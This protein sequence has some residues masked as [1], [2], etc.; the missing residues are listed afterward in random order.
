MTSAIQQDVRDAVEP[1]V[2]ERIWL[3]LGCGWETIAQFCPEKRLLS[4]LCWTPFFAMTR[5]NP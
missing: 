5:K 3:R 2:W 1:H 4:L